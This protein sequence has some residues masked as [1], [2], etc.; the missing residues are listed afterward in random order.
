MCMRNLLVLAGF[1]HFLY[2]FAFKS[3]SPLTLS[4]NQNFYDSSHFFSTYPYSELIDNHTFFEFIMLSSPE[5]KILRS[6]V[7]GIEYMYFQ[8]WLVFV[9]LISLCVSK[10][11]QMKKTCICSWRLSSTITVLSFYIDM[12]TISRIFFSFNV[13]FLT[14]PFNF[15][16]TTHKNFDPCICSYFVD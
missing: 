7:A 15:F 9:A 13:F 3:P 4:W 8:T 1:E 10:L 11:D 12:R 6:N 14:L 5:F 2:F 16:A